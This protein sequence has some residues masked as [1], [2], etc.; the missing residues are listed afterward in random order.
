[1]PIVEPCPAC[2]HGLLRG[3]RIFGAFECDVCGAQLSEL[4]PPHEHHWETVEWD[5]ENGG[6]ADHCFNCD[7][8]RETA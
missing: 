2:T 5:P 8:W 6:I 1:M 7:E 3:D 4:A